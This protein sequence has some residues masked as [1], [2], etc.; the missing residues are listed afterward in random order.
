M[1]I[2]HYWVRLYDS[3]IQRT[4]IRQWILQASNDVISQDSLIHGSNENDNS[5]DG[6]PEQNC[7]RDLPSAVGALALYLS[8]SSVYENA[9]DLFA[10]AIGAQPD[11]Q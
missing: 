2:I 11:W 3:G 4:H 8:R 7:A 9:V 10:E 1:W 6:E 5:H